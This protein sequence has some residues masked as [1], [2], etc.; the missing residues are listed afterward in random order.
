MAWPLILAVV[1]CVP[2]SFAVY[3]TDI[4]N[5]SYAKALLPVWAPLVLHATVTC[6]RAYRLR[7]SAGNLALTLLGGI[8]ILTII[9][10]YVSM[11]IACQFDKCINL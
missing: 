7:R 1:L 6:W 5:P 11:M 3:A 9:T 4:S 8:A 2:L 10:A